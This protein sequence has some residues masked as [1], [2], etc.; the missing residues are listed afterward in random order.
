MM[1]MTDVN[2]LALDA[3]PV[4]VVTGAESASS[5]WLEYPRPQ[6]VRSDWVSLDGSWGYATDD[7]D[8]GRADGWVAESGIFSRQIVVPF[9]PESPASGIGETGFH[10]VVWYRR[11]VTEAQLRA[12]GLDTQGSRMLLHFGAVDYRADVWLGGT[13]LGSH[14]GGHTPFSFDVSDVVHSV[15]LP[16]ELVVRAEDDPRDVAQP[17]GKQD[18]EA[19]PHGIWY[20]RTTGIW[21]PVWLEAVPQLHVTALSWSS[22]L[23]AGTVTL[24]LELNTRPRTRTDIGVQLHIGGTSLAECKVV[25]TEERSSHVITLPKQA[26]GQAYESRLWSPEHPRLVDAE[27]TVNGTDTVRSYLGLRNVGWAGGH[28]MLNDRPYYLRGIL[29]QGYWPTSHLAAPH[30]DALR[31]EVQLAKDLGFNMIRMHQKVEDPRFLAWADRIGMLVWAEAPSAYEFS[32]TAVSRLTTEWMNVIL[33]DRSHPSVVTWVPLNES[34]G[35]Q[36]IAH[37]PA[38][39]AFAKSLYHLTRALDPTRLVVSND[40]WEQVESDLVTVHDYGVTGDEIRANYLDRAAV[41]ATIGGIGPLGRRIQ[42]L[43]AGD[44]HRPVVVSEFGGVSYAP[45]HEGDGWGY[46]TPATPNAFRA[47]LADLFAALYSS[48]A[49][50]G[51]CYTQL[52]DTL[53]EV[54]GLADGNRRP[55]LRADAVRSIVLGEGIDTA[56]QRRPKQPIERPLKAD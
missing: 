34:W 27:V 2:L 55:K 21:Q 19:S 49:I 1:A 51:F 38:Q 46:A 56:W 13:Y 41:E 31:A 6:L 43:G 53:Q 22:N 52:T 30:P 10:P 42:L 25:V 35:V 28:F 37:D 39:Q 50:A 29:A 17:R 20:Q 14:E 4:D 3:V 9:P 44:P 11:Q 33:R 24:E 7:N 32:P 47:L 36:H 12:A 40:G 48:P 23:A 18:W 16:L 54:N 8:V 45:G 5:D 15:P 26:N